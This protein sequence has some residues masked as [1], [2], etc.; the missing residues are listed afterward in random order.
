MQVN[1]ITMNARLQA[2]PG[3]PAIGSIQPAHATYASSSRKLKCTARRMPKT[4]NKLI[5]HPSICL[6]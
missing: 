3:Q 1:S 2:T 6:K 4:R 5:D